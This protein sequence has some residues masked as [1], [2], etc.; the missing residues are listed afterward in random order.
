MSEDSVLEKLLAAHTE[1]DREQFE[2]IDQKLDQLTRDVA[3][4]KST[5]QQY[6]GF[7]GGVVFLATALWAIVALLGDAIAGWVRG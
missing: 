1:Q 7:I 4:L 6:K 3:E 2:K 5:V